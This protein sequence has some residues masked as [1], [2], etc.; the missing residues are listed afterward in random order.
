MGVYRGQRL[1]DLIKAYTGSDYEKN[2][3]EHLR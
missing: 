2:V 3:D 1:R